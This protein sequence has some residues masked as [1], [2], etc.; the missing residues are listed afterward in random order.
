MSKRRIVGISIGV[1]VFAILAFGVRRVQAKQ[2]MKHL[3]T[4]PLLGEGAERHAVVIFNPSSGDAA[5]VTK[6]H[7]LKVDASDTA[8][9][10]KG[11]VSIDGTVTMTGSN[12]GVRGALKEASSPD[13]G[14]P[15]T[16]TVCVEP[17]QQN[18]TPG[19]IF[20]KIAGGH[21]IAFK[22][23]NNIETGC[24]AVP[25]AQFVRLQGEGFYQAT[26]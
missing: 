11:T 7:A 10:V 18:G 13:L 2:N 6:D 4:V 14:F 26:Y 24:Y 8:Q 23:G 12:S 15:K 3:D 1:F 21:E 19:K 17:N 25:P 16:L 9:P 22:E 5:V 20:L